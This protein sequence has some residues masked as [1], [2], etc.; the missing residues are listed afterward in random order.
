[1]TTPKKKTT[2]RKAYKNM[3]V[4]EL[5]TARKELAEKITQIDNILAKAVEAVQSAGVRH[6]ASPVTYNRPSIGSYDPAFGSPSNYQPEQNLSAQVAISN[7]APIISPRPNNAQDQSSGFTIFDADAHARK[8]AEADHQY[9]VN[10][11]GVPVPP[12]YDF[13]SKEV[14]NEIQTLRKQIS[15]SKTNEAD[16]TTDIKE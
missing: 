14:V 1:M 11:P 6:T 16:T 8:Q 2:R 9:L 3:S 5:V 4:N 7:E 10:N 15:N 13:N 12:E